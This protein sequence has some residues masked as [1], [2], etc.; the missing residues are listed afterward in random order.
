MSLCLTLYSHYN[1][2]CKESPVSQ[3]MR[4]DLKR[5]TRAHERSR[6]LPELDVSR[7]GSKTLDVND[8]YPKQLRWLGG[9][10]S[11]KSSRR[12]ETGAG[13]EGKREDYCPISKWGISKRLAMQRCDIIIAVFYSPPKIPRIWVAIKFENEVEFCSLPSEYH[14]AISSFEICPTSM[15][16]TFCFN[17]PAFMQSSDNTKIVLKLSNAEFY[18]YNSKNEACP[19]QGLTKWLYYFRIRP[20]LII[21]CSKK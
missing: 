2:K 13:P 11:Q 16:N 5:L 12:A 4:W 18:F 3:R 14:Q 7:V 9:I 10:F 20:K 8:H 21:G 19:W 6:C 1:G 17:L 15:S